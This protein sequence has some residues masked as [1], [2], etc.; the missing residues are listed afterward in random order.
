MDNDFMDSNLLAKNSITD[1]LQSIER[2]RK[3]NLDQ[4]MPEEMQQLPEQALA[5]KYSGML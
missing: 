3:Y 2:N 5:G 1:L 4:E